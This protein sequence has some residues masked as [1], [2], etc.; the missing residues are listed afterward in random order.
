MDYKTV[1]A[2]GGVALVLYF[3]FKK[4]AEKAAA[5]AG[6][7][8]NPTSPSNVFY[9]GASAVTGALTGQPNISLGSEVYDLLNPEYKP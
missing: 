8:L 4:E 1:L 2:I 5:A 9:Q 7:A 6:A 3:V